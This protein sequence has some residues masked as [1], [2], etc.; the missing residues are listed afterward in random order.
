MLINVI[1]LYDKKI[2]TKKDRIS[3]C[4]IG[5]MFATTHFKDKEQFKEINKKREYKHGKTC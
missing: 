5:S 3:P 2:C 1:D 4:G